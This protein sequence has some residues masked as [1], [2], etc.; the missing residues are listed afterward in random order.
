MISGDIGHLN[1]SLLSLVAE[2]NPSIVMVADAEGT[3]VYVNL[4]FEE[5]T[6]YTRHEAVGRKL[7]MLISGRTSASDDGELWQTIRAGKVWT[8]EFHNRRKDGSLFWVSASIRGARGA[9]GEITHYVAI[10]EDI[11]DRKLE[12]ARF[13]GLL[14][15]APDAMV[16][17]DTDAVI[18]LVNA[19]TLRMFR[20]DRS[21]LVGR[22]IEVLVPEV[23]RARHVGLRRGYIGSPEA[24]S[25]GSRLELAGRR[26]DG[27]EFPVEVSL[28]PMATETGTWVVAAVRDVTE[29]RAIEHERK[30]LLE[31]LEKA[32]SQADAALDLT[33]AGYFEARANNV[34]YASDRFID[35]FG[36][37]PCDHGLYDLH[38]DLVE[39]IRVVAPDHAGRFVDSVAHTL[40]AKSEGFEIEFPFRRPSD[41]EVIWSR[42][43]AKLARHEGGASVELLGA[44]QDITGFKALERELVSARD[45]AESATRAKSEF[46]ANMS[47]EIRTPMNAIIGMTHL[48]LKTELQP[49]QRDYLE[50]TS[51][52]AHS[53][54]GIINDILDFS[55]IEAGKLAMETIPF[56]LE[57]VL[58]NLSSVI[59]YKAH[60]KGLEFLIHVARDV[61]ATLM[62]DPL[63]LGQ[64]L[65]NLASNAV[66]FTEH[67]EIA[68]RVTVGDFEADHT[69]LWFI[70]SD[71]G[72]GMSAEQ[73]SRLF[74]SFSQ[75]DASTTRR[76]GGTGL[77]LAISKH[78]VER[79]N[80][81]LAVESEPGRGST[82]SFDAV[83][84][85]RSRR[86]LIPSPHRRFKGLRVLIVDD[87]ASNRQILGEMLVE[88]GFEVTSVAS[89]R[90]AVRVVESVDSPFDVALMD[91][92]MPGMD[93]FETTRRLREVTSEMPTV[94][95]VT[96]HGS[97][98]VLTRAMDEGIAQVLMKPVSPSTLVDTLM[99]GLG[100]EPQGNLSIAHAS[101]TVD[102]LAG[103]R[104]L[105]VEDNDINQQV[106][107]ELLASAGI[108][109]EIASDGQ[110]AVDKIDLDRHDLVLMDCQMP[111][112]DG[113]EATRRLRERF[114]DRQ[115]PI[116]AMTANVMA[117]DRERVLAVG[118]QDHIAKP[119]D[120]AQLF[121]TLHRWV[122]DAKID[123]VGR[124]SASTITTPSH[125][126]VDDA[127]FTTQ[128]EGIDWRNGLLRAGGNPA[129]YRQLWGKFVTDQ[130]DAVERIEQ[131]LTSGDRETATRVAH[132]L[133]GVAGTL[134]ARSL[135]DAASSWESGLR[136]GR[137]TASLR[138]VEAVGLGLDAQL[139]ALVERIRPTFVVQGSSH[140]DASDFDPAAHATELA[141]IR[142]LLQDDDTDALGRLDRLLATANG[143]HP[144]LSEVRERVAAYEFEDGL[145]RLEAWLAGL[146][147]GSEKR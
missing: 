81:T 13:R 52:A 40:D 98:T 67:G 60:E 118:M 6:G 4:R 83:F 36:L 41:G 39:H 114:T 106:A 94:I 128:L 77:G 119:V 117:G 82:F 133:K 56:Q 74:Q 85:V 16:I 33:R 96:A 62:G 65:L 1:V 31:A 19:Q 69:R 64:V 130:A 99:Q 8:G 2:Q 78:L 137:T 143:F 136:E 24:R 43:T 135:Q 116:I 54:L 53:L 122:T 144:V 38:R 109:F 134:G 129:L 28:S 124:T 107:S 146:S 140:T 139:R 138:A 23:A 26:L 112:M 20:C 44:A 55:K 37:P 30:R 103:L 11:T 73:Q 110:S 145:A 79:M 72:I 102:G 45:G 132:T 3:L 113:F 105:L 75:A 42:T 123:L 141:E 89:G 90:E 35:L 126:G 46:L 120:P 57:E 51:R 17:V 71:T 15:S 14:E 10:E 91:W 147:V 108:S 59:S 9:E 48:A 111:V 58:T 142:V 7:S 22:P 88:L 76:F 92:Q 87:N 97:E 80:G 68:V 12:E 27:K 84:G 131:A 49:K 29:R 32:R 101:T 121:A 34:L 100:G 63:R 47:H 50:K 127:F 66:K 25:M 104:V 95:M 61:P 86:S 93:G 18:R 5:V 21:E 115:L 70:V 125:D